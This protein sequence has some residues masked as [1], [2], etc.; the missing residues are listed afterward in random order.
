LSGGPSPRE[1]RS[2]RR[3][4]VTRRAAY[5]VAAPAIV[6]LLRLLWGTY[7]FTVVGD[8]GTRALAAEGSPLI[9]TLWHDSV[10]VCAW[11]LKLLGEIGVRP[12]YLVSPSMDGELAVRLLARIDGH[13]VRGSATRSGV[14]AMHGLYRAMVR[15]K[16]SPV[17]LPDGPQ[18]PRH[19]CKP[20][21]LL[22]GQ[23][24]GA[25]I[26]PMACAASRSW[27]LRTWDRQLVPGPFSRVAIVLGEPYRLGSRLSDSELDEER[28]ALEKRLLDL[29]A[30]AEEL[31]AR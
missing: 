7:R 22:L 27:H 6:G 9:L 26:Q 12:T 8:E 3:L 10:F 15:D 4:S 14:K 25:P 28:A 13:V 2:H 29:T 5:A 17:I 21:S 11:Y 31:V 16:A 19:S 24:S 20:G 30:A 23:L 1:H 18:G